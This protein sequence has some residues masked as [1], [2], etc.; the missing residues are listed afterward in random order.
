MDP[1][2][3]S[4][5]ICPG[6]TLNLFNFLLTL[7]ARKR[8]P[9][10]LLRPNNALQSHASVFNY[11]T[12]FGDT[13]Y[14]IQNSD[15]RYKHQIKIFQSVSIVGTDPFSEENVERIDEQMS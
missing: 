3:G 6:H 15:T 13:R 4:Q 8:T 11:A 5:S 10:S 9:R 1:A 14:K 2:V 12:C 7:T